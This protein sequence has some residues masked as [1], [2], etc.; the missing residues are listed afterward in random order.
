[1]VALIFNQIHG[2]L[3]GVFARHRVVVGQYP[4]SAIMVLLTGNAQNREHHSGVI[5]VGDR[6]YRLSPDISAA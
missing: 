6:V 2:H 4:E 1:M 3:R 5:F